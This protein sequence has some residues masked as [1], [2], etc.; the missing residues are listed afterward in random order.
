MIRQAPG[1]KDWWTPRD[2][3]EEQAL[4]VAKE[5]RR[6]REPRSAQW[7]AERTKELG[8]EMTRSVISDLENGRRRY[9]TSAELIVL[10][11]A[12]NTSLIALML[13]PPY[14]EEIEMLPGVPVPKL[15]AV[16]IFCDNTN[17]GK[18]TRAL[19]R[20]RQIATIKH[21]QRKL[22]TQLAELPEQFGDDHERYSAP[23]HAQLE[24]VTRWL[25]TWEGED[26]KAW[27]ALDDGG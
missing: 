15:V 10:A 25:D 20:A 3:G 12:L 17:T 16:E 6:L 13:P 11:A 18:R 7:L 8:Y 5:V 26:M 22:L 9:V 27:E 4:R 14:D 23:L 21:Q 2:W 24:T 19:Q 1:P